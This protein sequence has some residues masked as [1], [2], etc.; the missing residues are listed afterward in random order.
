MHDPP[1]S[2]VS[3]ALSLGETLPMMGK[4]FGHSNIEITARYTHLARNSVGE[5][6]QR[7]AVSIAADTYCRRVGFRGPRLTTRTRGGS[8]PRTVLGRQCIFPWGPAILA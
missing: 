8:V 6:A 3:G 2:F 7:I 5:S 4:L 1:R